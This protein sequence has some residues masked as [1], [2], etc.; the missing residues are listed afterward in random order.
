MFK[1]KGTDKIISLPVS[2][3]H[4]RH[5]FNQFVI[6]VPKRDNLMK[7]LKDCHIGCEVYYPVALHNQACFAYLKYKKGS[8]PVAEQAAA[9]TLAIPIYPELTT[10]QKQYVVDKIHEFLTR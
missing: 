5:I 10:A 7:Y 8:F 3:D 9:E 2:L 6:R 4:Y 1:A